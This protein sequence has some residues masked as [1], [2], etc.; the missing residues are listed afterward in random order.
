MPSV[1]L[2]P[3]SETAG[4]R[5]R[6]VDRFSDAELPSLL[7]GFV[8]SSVGV[9]EY[10][11]DGGVSWSGKKTLWPALGGNFGNDLSSNIVLLLDDL[12]RP[13][14]F[15]PNFLRRLAISP[16]WHSIQNIPCEVLAYRRFSIFFLQFRQR[17]QVA[18]K[19]WSPVRIAKSSILL[20][21]ALQLYVQLLQM[22]E[23]SPRRSRFA[24]ESRRVPQV[25]QR[26]Q[27][28]CHRLPARNPLVSCSL[29]IRGVP[30]RHT[31]FES[32]SFFKYLFSYVLA[33]E[34]HQL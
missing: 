23:P 11:S 17:K 33:D 5:S 32:F 26:K 20:P 28:I 10:A 16:S 18:Q 21:Q 8:G 29:G 13:D 22:R 6:F 3:S 25:L 19:A 4:E 24:S 12:C 1:P 2:R 14:E 7:G 15:F 9:S 27:L 34:T 31:K 30:I